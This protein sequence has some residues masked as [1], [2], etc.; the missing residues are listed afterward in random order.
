MPVLEGQTVLVTGA[1]QGLGSAIAR[2]L[3][4]LGARLILLDWDEEGLAET[5]IACPGATSTVVDLADAGATE[6]AVAEVVTSPVDT[7]IHNL[8]L[9]HI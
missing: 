3:H 6:R 4:G 8:S 2:H 9:I 7:L 1:A 5:L